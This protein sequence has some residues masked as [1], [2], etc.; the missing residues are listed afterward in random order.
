V[1]SGLNPELIIHSM[2]EPLLAAQV[3]FCRL[4]GYMPKEKLN[5]LQFTS[6]IMAEASARPPEIMWSKF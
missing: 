4:D 1:L 5:L 3:F 2:P 6:R